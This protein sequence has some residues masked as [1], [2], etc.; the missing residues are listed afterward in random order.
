MLCKL[1]SNVV[2]FVAEQTYSVTFFRCENEMDVLPLDRKIQHYPEKSRFCEQSLDHCYKF[3]MLNRYL[4]DQQSSRVS[5]IFCWTPM[6]VK[7]RQASFGSSSVITT[8][9]DLSE[10]RYF[11]LNTADY[12]RYRGLKLKY[13]IRQLELSNPQC[14]SYALIAYNSLKIEN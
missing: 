14:L 9:D 4:N 1:V 5:C 11:L 12:L 6:T 8:V 3:V 10:L 2:K 13:K 7:Y